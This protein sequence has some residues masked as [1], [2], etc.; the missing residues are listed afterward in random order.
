MSIL[1]DFTSFVLQ[2]LYGVA[3]VAAIGALLFCIAYFVVTVGSLLVG[4][5]E[6]K[7]T[8]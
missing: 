5:G 4:D 3:L 7:E 1:W 2:V 6:D 8:S